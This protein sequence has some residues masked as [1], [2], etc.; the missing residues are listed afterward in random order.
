VRLALAAA[1]VDV[2]REREDGLLRP[3][4][5]CSSRS[6]MEGV[7]VGARELKN[8]WGHYLRQVR[9]GAT[10]YVTDRG[11]IVAE[12]KP[13]PPVK[14]GEAEALRRLAAEGAITLGAGQHEDVAPAPVRRAKTLTSRMIIADRR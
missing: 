14:S 13:S 11:R 8:R 5:P 6:Y 2:A 7:Q 4:D 12:L 3:L 1:Y 10:V 9:S